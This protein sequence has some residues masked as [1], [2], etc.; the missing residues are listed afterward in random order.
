M[1]LTLNKIKLPPGSQSIVV[2]FSYKEYYA[3]SFTPLAANITI[4]P[5]G[6]IS[7]A[8]LSITIN[9][10]NKYVLRAE[11]VLCGFLYEQNVMLNP[12]CEPG[13]VLSP[14]GT[15]CYKED[16]VSA[17][18]PINPQVTIEKNGI[19]YGT[20]GTYIYS[21]G[22]NLD[23]TGTS[24]KIPVTNSFWYNGLGN[25]SDGDTVSGPINRAGLW[26]T[27]ATENQ[28]IGYSK[29]ITVPE[30]KV[31]YVGIACDNY[32]IIRLDAT[33]IVSQN[34]AALNTKY[35]AVGACFKVFHIYPV[36]IPKGNRILEG[37]GHNTAGPAALAVEIYDNT[38]A[39]IMA[40][41]S[42]A[43]LNV[44]FSTKDFIGEE[45][46]IGSG[47]VGWGCP[48]SDYSLSFCDD[49]VVCKRLIKVPIKY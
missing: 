28:D 17:T 22:F 13:Y 10:A 29:C 46:Q 30:T 15:Y 42:Y 18:S 32:G 44:I 43:N 40:A 33:T 9:P 4:N 25:C 48:S 37:I 14:D 35:S 27:V 20:C 8:P 3:D 34:E 23:G 12:Y 2:N 7:G 16:V 38:A 36:L 49:P 6:T 39:E 41:T 26:T 1:Q 45:V 11:N 19:S 5:D 21:P 24:T 31:Y 47:G